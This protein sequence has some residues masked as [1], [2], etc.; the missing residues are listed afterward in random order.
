[1]LFNEEV[2]FHR[3]KKAAENGFEAVEIQFP[4]MFD[5]SLILDKLE[6]VFHYRAINKIQLFGAPKWLNV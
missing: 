5:K 6:V 2:F 4:Y 1:M 3:F